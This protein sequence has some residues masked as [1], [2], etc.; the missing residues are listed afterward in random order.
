MKIF[1]ALRISLLATLASSCLLNVAHADDA[2][3][4]ELTSNQVV[5]NSEGKTIYTPVRTAP[6]GTVIQYKATYTNTINKDINDLMVTLP[7]PTNMTFT[8]EAVPASAQASTD[9][10]NY[11]DMPL[12]RKV[13]GKMVKV[14]YSEY[15]TLRW[16]IKLLPAKKS[17]AVA[18]NTTVN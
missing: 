10:K 2:L 11:A 9:G 3:K 5:K 6:A 12:M 18:L 4:M 13:D 1:N 16:N 15:R 8:G 7:I 17:A 14:P